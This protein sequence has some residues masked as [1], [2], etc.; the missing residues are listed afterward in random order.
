M[1]ETDNFFYLHASGKRLAS[2]SSPRTS[3]NPKVCK[4]SKQLIITY[5]ATKVIEVGNKRAQGGPGTLP[6]FKF[7]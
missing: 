5:Q 1:S 7:S 4:L 6:D 3:M 2:I